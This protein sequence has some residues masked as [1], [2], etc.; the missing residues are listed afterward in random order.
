MLKRVLLMLLCF[1]IVFSFSACG[2][3]INKFKLETKDLNGDDDYS[4][5]VFTEDDICNET[6][7]AYC[8]IYGLNT[9]GGTSYQ[10]EE[11]L[12][13]ADVVKADAQSPFSGVA[14]LQTTYGT[15][16]TITFTVACER[17]KGNVKIVLLDENAKI[18]HD[19]SITEKSS[20]TVTNVMGRSFE[21]RVAG[22]SAKFEVEVLREFSN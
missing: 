12:H 11:Y 4:L 10:D 2:L 15:H 17:T 19:F 8:V 3:L 20:F 16:N 9:S 1:C 7:D 18:I 6:C 14:L 22:E 21:I 13:D 5:V